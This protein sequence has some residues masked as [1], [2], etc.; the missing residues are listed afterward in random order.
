MSWEDKKAI[1]RI[2]NTFKRVPKQVFQEDIDA[3]K[4]INESL[5]AKASETAHDNLLY[6]KLLAVVL[7]HNVAYFGNIQQAIKKVKDDELLKKEKD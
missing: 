7:R 3:L 4:T 5:E 2:F 1:R 6:A